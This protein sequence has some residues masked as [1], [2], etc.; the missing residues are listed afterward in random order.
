MIRQLALV[1]FGLI[2]G[3]TVAIAEP[4]PVELKKTDDGWQLLRGG[5]PYFIRG[6]GGSASIEQLAAAGANSIRTWR[7]EGADTV[8]DE[9]H[10]H[11]M[12]VTLGIWLEHER[13]GFDYDDPDQVAEQLEY[14]RQAVLKYRDHPALLLWGIGNETEGFE[15]GD[16]QGVWNAVN[17]IAAMVKELDPHH[18]TMVVTVEVGGDRIAAIHERG[19]DIDIHGINSYGGAPT[20]AKRL[21]KGG[22]HKPF[23]I[24]EFGSLGP[25]ESPTASWGAPREQTSTEK[26]AFYRE[27]YENSILGFPGQALG[28][29]VFLWGNKMEGTATWFGMFLDTGAKLAMVDTMTELW[30]GKLPAD[31]APSIEPLVV[32][33]GTVLKP[34][35]EIRV[36]AK[37]ADP[38]G[39]PVTFEWALRTESG[40]YK[41]GGDR[42]ERLPDI[43]AAVVASSAGEATIRMPEKPGSYRVFAYAYDKA[44]NAATA[45][46]PL[47]VKGA[48]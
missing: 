46:L 11:G 24:T 31:Q 13:H 42:R 17:D 34:G 35:A 39:G 12:T 15:A 20:V 22:G 6:A 47:L 44:G 4:V 16:D 21:R 10:K 29:Y 2:L 26:A 19:P 36:T 27:S 14:A 5:E 37:A 7:V 38:E 25:W 41:T 32:E 30:T 3:S 18:P 8:L 28:S 40:D 43:E 33:P 48:Q 1:I 23:V 45:N 9:A